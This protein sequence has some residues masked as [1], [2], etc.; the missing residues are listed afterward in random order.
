LLAGDEWE[1][2]WLSMGTLPILKHSKRPLISLQIH[3][4]TE[5][6]KY[7]FKT[8]TD[9]FKQQKNEYTKLGIIPEGTT[10]TANFSD[11]K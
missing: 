2:G 7:M 3:N 11:D 8:F 4:H 9:T 6:F 10:N 5:Y 1:K